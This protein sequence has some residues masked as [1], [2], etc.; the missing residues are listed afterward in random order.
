MKALEKQ[1]KE[2]KIN[3][4]ASI[5]DKQ[6]AIINAPILDVWNLLVNVSAW[7]EWNDEIKKVHCEKVEEGAEFDWTIRHMHLRSKF[8]VIQEPTLMTWVGKSNFVKA[9]FVW[10]LE[11]SD[12]Q[13]IVTV[14]ESVEG[15]V[16]P[17]FNNHT[18]LHDIL[19]DWLKALKEKA[20]S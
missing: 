11:A 20:E 8:Q 6:S 19:V 18:K 7:P 16:V 4:N 2:G 12:E 17:I 1:A 14:E 5:R 15:F 3:E 10:E 13:T 9:I